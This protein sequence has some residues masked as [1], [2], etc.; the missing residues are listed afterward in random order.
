MPYKIKNWNAHF[1]NAK[2]RS[3]LKKTWGNLPNKQDGLGYGLVMRQEDGAAIYGGFVAL[4]LMCSKQASP[5]DGWI[6]ED[7]KPTG[8]PLSALEISI[9]TQMPETVIE[10]V[11]EVTSSD[12]V[13]WVED[14]AGIPQGYREDT[15]RP[16]SIPIREWR[17]G[18]EGKEGK[19]GEEGDYRHR[20]KILKNDISIK[21][22]ISTLRAGH[23]AFSAVLDVHLQN[24]LKGQ[25][26]RE[27]WPEAIEGLV[28]AY[29]GADLPRPNNALKNWLQG[30]PTSA[31]GATI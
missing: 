23:P 29:A 19:E 15:T 5:R 2:S 24:T 4:V 6:T 11:L 25:P 8:R 14:T 16:S 31:G 9:K 18:E 1:E 28:A 10:R 27:R 22:A 30:K 21:N 7:G 26:D 12:P 20:L 3:I 13:G 17:E